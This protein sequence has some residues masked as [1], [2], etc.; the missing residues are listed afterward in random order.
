MYQL[1]KRLRAGFTVH[2]LRSSFSDWA[3]EATG[4]DHHSIE[5]SLAHSIGSATEKAYRRSDLLDKR[6]RL[7][8]AWSSYCTTPKNET[9][10]V[11]PMRGHH[12]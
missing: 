4:F 6:R 5:L 8:Q 12:A 1:L 9:A 3:H 11:V 2:G 7:M 10:D